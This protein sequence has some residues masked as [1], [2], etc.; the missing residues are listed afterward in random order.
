MKVVAIIASTYIQGSGAVAKQFWM[1]GA[2]AC[3][4]SS[5]STD[6]IFGASELY[7]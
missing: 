7:K 5:S 2:G 1:A 6:L 3:N 4:V